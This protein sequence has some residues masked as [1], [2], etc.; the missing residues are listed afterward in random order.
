[1][2]VLA[3]DCGR[4]EMQLHRLLDGDLPAVQADEVNAHFR[5]CPRCARFYASLRQNLVLHRWADDPEFDLDNVA[6]CLPGDIPDYHALADRLRE[7]D[8]SQLGGVLYEILKA[9]FLF[10]Y[11]DDLEVSEAPIVDPVHE[12]A[13]GVDLVEGLRD[14]HDA[15]EV[16]GV[17]LLALEARLRPA[18]ETDRLSALVRGMEAVK[19]LD[20]ARAHHATYYQGLAHY[21]AG[22]LGAA[23][24]AFGE[25]ARSGPKGLARQA[26][27]TLAS[28]PVE[29]GDDPGRAVPLLEA[30]LAGDGLDAMV[31]F[32][33]AKAH[34]LLAQQQMD[35]AAL[36]ALAEARR[37]DPELVARQLARPS[38]AG[39]RGAKPSTH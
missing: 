16:D 15:D 37:R 33:L 8:F 34:F 6:A 2:T 38:E 4:V 1:M 9:E 19:G 36:T 7:A 30:A 20:P 14:W 22:R 26:Q 28:L 24:A 3:F 18:E 23:E 25:V 13:R 10:D 5:T 39:M 31:Y 17:D 35:V 27:V 21:K 32:N 12:R 11:G 29:S